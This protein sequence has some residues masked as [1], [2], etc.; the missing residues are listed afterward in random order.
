MQFILP[1]GKQLPQ[2][3]QLRIAE[4]FEPD[5]D[6]VDI[7]RVVG[8]CPNLEELMLANVTHPNSPNDGLTALEASLTSLALAGS[9]FTDSTAAAQQPARPGMVWSPE[10]L[11]K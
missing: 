1:A 3:K 4:Y 5:Y 6:I 2:L 11:H 9:A 10:Q 7:D 8:C